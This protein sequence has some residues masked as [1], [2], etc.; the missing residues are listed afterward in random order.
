[1][2]GSMAARRF[3]SRFMAAVVVGLEALRRIDLLTAREN[4]ISISLLT[5]RTKCGSSLPLKDSAASRADVFDRVVFRR[6]LLQPGSCLILALCSP[7]MNQ[8]S[9]VLNSPKMS[10]QR[11]RQTPADGSV[12]KMRVEP[13]CQKIFPGRRAFHELY[14]LRPCRA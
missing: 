1:M 13:S 12:P 3:I 9:S 8:K 4:S 10:Q 2:M 7:V 5:G 14:L 6:L 11:R